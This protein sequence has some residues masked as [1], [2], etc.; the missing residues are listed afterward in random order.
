MKTNNVLIPHPFYH[1]HRK[2]AFS[3]IY[4]ASFYLFQFKT[5]L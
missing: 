2:Y 3:G 1:T 5:I 4:M